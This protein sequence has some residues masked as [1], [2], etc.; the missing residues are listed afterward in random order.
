MLTIIMLSVVFPNAMAPK[1]TR[2]KTVVHTK[3]KSFKIMMGYVYN[4]EK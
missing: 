4:K 2:I 1:M 3:K